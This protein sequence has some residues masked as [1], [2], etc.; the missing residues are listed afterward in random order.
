[1]AGS[2]IFEKGQYDRAIELFERAL[3]IEE[4][5]LGEMHASTAA[6]RTL[7]QPT[8][9]RHVAAAYSPAKSMRLSTEQ[10]DIR[11]NCREKT[12]SLKL[13]SSIDGP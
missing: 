3:R 13:R 6:T 9:Q 12:L 5:T 2:F 1:M 10:R 4:A 11:K 7:L 8:Q